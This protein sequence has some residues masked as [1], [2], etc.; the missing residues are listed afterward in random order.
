MIYSE[1]IC[2]SLSQS[3]LVEGPRA[4][5]NLLNDQMVAVLHLKVG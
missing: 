5:H 4:W 1:D 3:S 2:L